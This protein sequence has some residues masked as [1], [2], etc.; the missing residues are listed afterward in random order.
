MVPEGIKDLSETLQNNDA[1]SAI[2]I[3]TIAYNVSIELLAELKT[4]VSRERLEAVSNSVASRLMWI[5][6]GVFEK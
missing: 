4:E 1:L 2:W 6:F 5:L 3:D